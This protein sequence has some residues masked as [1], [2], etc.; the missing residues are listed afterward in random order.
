M[1]HAVVHPE[2]DPALTVRITAHSAI[3]G[4]RAGSALLAVGDR[5]LVVGDDAH[6]ATWIEPSSGGSRAQVLAGDGGVLPKPLK[7]DFEAAVVDPDGSVWLLGSG[8]LSNRW[9][10]TR[11]SGPDHAEVTSYDRAEVYAAIATHLG[12]APNLEGAV[13][14]GNVLRVCHRSTG[15]LPDVVIDLPSDVLRGGRTRVLATTRLAPAVVGGVPA[16]VTDLALLPDG[17]IAFLAAAEDTDDP[18]ADGPVAGT[19]FGILEGDR[20]WWAPILEADGSPSTRK[21][22]GLVIDPD[23]SG[24]WL[25]TD[26][27]DPS[28]P[29]ELCRF[30]L[31]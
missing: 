27:D 23:G 3:D 8:S 30:T 2:L 14:A 26:R 18:V 11:L 17:R 15:A 6:T 16:H 12:T 25:V 22:E 20:A 7:P 28:L 21:A 13:F 29:A 24:G 1:T 31:R 10:V 5:L 19:V 4:V 9:L